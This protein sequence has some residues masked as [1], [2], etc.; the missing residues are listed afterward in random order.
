MKFGAGVFLFFFFP[1]HVMLLL[2]IKAF[3]GK[4]AISK[5]VF[6]QKGTVSSVF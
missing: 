5:Y 4:T 3:F 1:H 2:E 6:G